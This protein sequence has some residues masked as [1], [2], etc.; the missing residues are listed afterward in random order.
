[1]PKGCGGGDGS[2]RPAVAG[3]VARRTRPALPDHLR[4][5][6]K[7]RTSSEIPSARSKNK[8]ANVV[9]LTPFALSILETL[10]RFV[11]CDFVFTTTRK[12]AVS[13]FSKML[14]RISELSGTKDWHLHD[15]RRTAASGMAQVGVAPHVVEKVLNHSSGIISGVAAVYNRYGY[16]TEKR[17]ALEAWNAYLGGLADTDL[18]QAVLNCPPLPDMVMKVVRRYAHG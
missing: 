13:G 5:V 1:M 17:E 12:T 3:R 18:G 15:L 8:R 10:P 6:R 16:V 2:A 7:S 4:L 14:A 9:P 11:N